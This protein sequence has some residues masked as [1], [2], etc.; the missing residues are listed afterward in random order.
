VQ[1]LLHELE[2]QAR[3]EVQQKG[4]RVYGAERCGKASPYDRARSWEPLRGCN[5]SFAVGR[6][7]REALLEA[8]TAPRA[9]RTRVGSR[10][11]TAALAAARE[12]SGEGS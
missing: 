5:P 6:G 9:F 4:W 8:V 12:L 11:A 1:R 3:V 10:V 7:Q 2:Q